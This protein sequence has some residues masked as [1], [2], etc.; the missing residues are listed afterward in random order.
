MIKIGQKFSEERIKKGLSIEDVAK[1]TKI[2]A[3]FISAIEKGDY[4]NLPSSAYAVGFVKNYSSFLGLPEKETIAL[5]RREFDEKKVF[6]VL[7]RGLTQDA[8]FLANRFRLQQRVIIGL[9]I[10][11]GL[12]AYIGFQYRYTFISPL[13]TVSSPKEKE[14]F[15]VSDVQVL[16]K[17]D[18]N[19]I[20]YVND[21]AVSVD[22]NGEFKKTISLFEGKETITIK[23]VNRFG[24]ETVLNREVEIKPQ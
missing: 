16:G 12:S 7:P 1:E 9:L 4:K 20:V 17:T 13:L 2:R 6:E 10:F 24:R 5:F 22:K 3:S 11:F 19:A 14:T 8:D 15:S 18:Q 21:I 23:A